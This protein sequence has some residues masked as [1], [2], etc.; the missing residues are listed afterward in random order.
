MAIS[1]LS[2]LV[3]LGLTL[4]WPLLWGGMMGAIAL[5]MP[6]LAADIE[7]VAPQR[8]AAGELPPLPE[9]FRTYTLARSFALHIPAHWSATGD[10]GDRTATLTQPGSDTAPPQAGDITTDVTFLS[11]SPNTAIPQALDAIIASGYEVTE[12]R[13][14]SINGILGLRLRLAN[15]PEDYPY[16]FITY[17][18][19]A[20]YGTAILV[21]R[22]TDDSQDTHDIL[23]QV[24]GSFV[25]VYR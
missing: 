16:Q 13:F 5:G 14:L 9:G 7:V 25:P 10:E 19:Y 17:I 6:T 15:I 18:G 20:S 8:P 21:S 4:R 11:E 2:T 23:S 22:H 3:T 1:P 24:H 12:Y